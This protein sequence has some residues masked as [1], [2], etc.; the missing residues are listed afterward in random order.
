MATEF[1]PEESQVKFVANQDIMDEEQ[2]WQ[3]R[4]KDHLVAAYE[5]TEA[6]HFLPETLAE[7]DD[8]LVSEIHET[9]EK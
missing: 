3:S 5:I 1:T 2:A 4:G 9:E 8:V 6:K 7:Q